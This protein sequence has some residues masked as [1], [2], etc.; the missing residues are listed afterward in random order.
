[1]GLRAEDAGEL[2]KLASRTSRPGRSRNAAAQS[3]SAVADEDSHRSAAI[4]RAT[5]MNSK[6][7][8]TDTVAPRGTR[9]MLGTSSGSLWV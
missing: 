8:I 4:K 3:A 6:R 1:M 5:P 9:R 2:A 7:K